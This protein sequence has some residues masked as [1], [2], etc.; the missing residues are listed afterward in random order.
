MTKKQKKMIKDH[1]KRMYNMRFFGLNW[2]EIHQKRWDGDDCLNDTCDC[3]EI[4][5]EKT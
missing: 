3:V 1:K 4:Y 2:Q 5:N